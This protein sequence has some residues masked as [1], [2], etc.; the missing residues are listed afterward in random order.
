MVKLLSEKMKEDNKVSPISA[1]TTEGEFDYIY[2]LIS[3]DVERNADSFDEL[4]EIFDRCKGMNLNQKCGDI[5]THIEKTPHL[6]TQYENYKR[7][8]KGDYSSANGQEV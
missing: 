5:I 7:E 6:K 3:E 2:R 8:S 1:V 4:V